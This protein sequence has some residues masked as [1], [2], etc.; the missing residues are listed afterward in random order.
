M[1]LCV[2]VCVCVSVCVCDLCPSGFPLRKKEK[3]EKKM[4]VIRF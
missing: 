4:L 1:H 2:C 3:L